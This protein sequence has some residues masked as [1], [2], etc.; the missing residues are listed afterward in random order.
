MKLLSQTKIVNLLL[1]IGMIVL[2]LC[3]IF[4]HR[5]VKEISL[6]NESILHT[7]KVIDT[8]NEIL[9]NLS[10]AES[11]VNNYLR[12]QEKSISEKIVVFINAL[13]EKTKLLIELTKDN[14]IEQ[15]RAK[16]LELLVNERINL[17]KEV[18]KIGSNKNGKLSHSINQN[19]EKLTKKI[20][21]L[22]NNINKEE[23]FLL[24]QR[25][26]FS[27]H[28]IKV[29]NFIID[30][31]SLTSELLI[32]FSI[33][34]LNYSLHKRNIAE[35]KEKEA[36]NKMLLLNKRLQESEDQYLIATEASSV[37]LWDWK[38]GTSQVIYFPFFKKMLGYS[39]KEF[40][41]Q[42]ESFEKIIHP[43][44][45]DQ[46][47][48][49]VNLH[50]D[51]HVPFI[52]EYRLRNKSGIYNWFRATGQAIW[53]ESGKPTRM[54]GSITDI[55]NNKMAE[56]SLSIQHGIAE[57]LSEG[58]S[59]DDVSL[60][61]IR[62]ICESLKWDF[63]SL[64]ELDEQ[65]STLKCIKTWASSNSLKTF[66]DETR[67]VKFSY[68][69]GLPGRAWETGKPVW[70]ADIVHD[71]KFTRAK[72]AQ[73]IGL[74]SAFAFP[75]YVKDKIFGAIECYTKES[76]LP[77]KHILNLM[78]IIGEQIG[79]FMNRKV[80][81]Y[82]L[83]ESEEYQAA[84]LN[85]A[86]DCIIT[87]DNKNN[88]LSFNSQTEK[89]FG[90]SGEELLNTSI[91]KLLPNYN[92]NMQNM[93]NKNYIETE[94]VRKN[95]E[96]FSVEL[97]ISKMNIHDQ[98]L[99]VIMIRNI[100]DRKKIEKMKNEFI[101]VV[102]HELRTPLTSISG[103]MSLVLGGAGGALTEKTKGLLD[104]ANNN[105]NRLLTLIND[106]LDVEK[107]AAG[108]MKF[109]LKV[110]DINQLVNEAIIANT[111]YAKRLDVTLKSEHS[112][113][114]LKVNVDPDRLMQVI[115]NLL[116]NAI[117]F[118]PKN[119]E[120]TISIKRH[121]NWVSV[122]VS[123]KGEGIPA[124]FQSKIF[125]KF[126]QADSSNIRS[127]GGTGLGLNISKTII[128]KLGGKI[129][130]VSK[131]GELTTFYFDL[132]LW[133][134]TAEI[135]N[136]QQI[137]A[138]KDKILIC[139]DDEDQANYLAKLLESSGFSV[140]VSHDAHEAKQFLE[141]ESYHVL[142]LDLILPGQDGISFIRE[143]RENEK[144]RELPIIVLSI[145]A[146]TGHNLLTGEAI[147]VVDW[148]DKPVDFDKL[149]HTIKYI[150]TTFNQKIPDILHVEDDP[151]TIE[152]VKTLLKSEANVESATSIKEMESMLKKMKFD[153]VILDL[154]LPDGNAEKIIP[155]ISKYNLPI[156]VYSTNA[157]DKNLEKSVSQSLLKSDNINDKLL[158]LIRH[159]LGKS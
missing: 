46:L 98:N 114:G 6:A 40:P 55:Q 52:A 28:Q 138:I 15:T 71:V 92:F 54:V 18:I 79:L 93:L 22:I 140:T 30:V 151:I 49:R 59:L 64:W 48:T 133:E 144:T 23:I 146:K 102:S 63:G 11:R 14:V 122:S 44:D 72:I 5:Q 35:K 13:V 158:S 25:H 91:E 20:I 9:L 137:K 131:P 105:C 148:L 145:I 77:D 141:N 67:K 88:I 116:S 97:K 82:K 117:K 56:L 16:E 4:S 150:N 120:V 66:D 107:L 100:S 45:H 106:I 103:V 69:L 104:L 118:S 17:M 135:I 2:A 121:K 61:I 43:Q 53:D 99:F 33:I 70:F 26:A 27:Y 85:A 24:E 130:F 57:I 149:I 65:E 115:T 12:G 78:S 139:E 132:P 111:I 19:R 60:E 83:K 37:G 142:L 8:S 127:K 157:L 143:L 124:D 76:E 31:F 32:L 42:L 58:S 10:Q 75:I 109:D 80:A 123:N 62:K 74:S 101:S 86:S 36:E 89:E 34:L 129:N 7:H 81:E 136:D 154:I 152:Y 159:I 156:V 95:G 155:L 38:V 110:M 126:S 119:E 73:E 128:E 47:W 94:A 50:L 1:I 29:G 108:K 21:Q 96:N 147:S 125:Q 39:D 134:S 68:G 84:I 41:N 153:L 3:G 51:K 87:I 113:P 90:Y 112:S